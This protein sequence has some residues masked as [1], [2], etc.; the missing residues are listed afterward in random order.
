M[1]SRSVTVTD[2]HPT[3]V[4][5]G[6]Q[7]RCCESH[8]GQCHS[9]GSRGRI[10]RDAEL[11]TLD[12]TIRAR[13]LVSAQIEVRGDFLFPRCTF[14]IQSLLILQAL[15]TLY[16]NSSPPPRTLIHICDEVVRNPFLFRWYSSP[17]EL[18]E[19]ST[20]MSLESRQGRWSFL[21]KE[22]PLRKSYSD[23]APHSGVQRIVRRCISC[24]TQCVVHPFRRNFL[25]LIIIIDRSGNQHNSIRALVHIFKSSR[26]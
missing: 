18:E 9:N 13:R 14:S 23:L 6:R 5:R 10:R 26:A 1:A 20:R 25:N 3:R 7:A 19:A 24:S 2:Y 8:P 17:R 11:P 16:A 22:I 12:A 4:F 21:E 15:L